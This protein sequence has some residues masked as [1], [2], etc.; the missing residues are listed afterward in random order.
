MVAEGLDDPEERLR[1]HAGCP[2]IH[3]KRKMTMRSSLLLLPV[4]IALLWFGP[5]PIRAQ[6][7]AAVSTEFIYN[8][9]DSCGQWID[10]DP[11]GYCWHPKDT[12]TDWHPYTIGRWVRTDAGWTWESDERFGWIVYHYG[13]WIR[14]SK[15]GWCWVPDTKWAPAWVSFREGGERVG[16]APLPPEARLSES[17]GIGEWAD[18]YYNIGPSA[19]RFLPIQR[20]G[21]RLTRE[22]FL[23]AADNITIFPGTVN[24]TSIQVGKNGVFVDGP[25]FNALSA[26]AEHPVVRMR[27][28][29]RDEFRS[30]NPY[31]QWSVAD[32]WVIVAPQAL[33][34]AEME[35]PR[36]FKKLLN[37]HI[38]HG[39]ESTTDPVRA[40]ELQAKLKA[41]E[42]LPPSLPAVPRFE[43]RLQESLGKTPLERF[44]EQSYIDRQCA[45]FRRERRSESDN[46]T[47]FGARKR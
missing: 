29:R 36:L 22:S 31:G 44:R 9:L 21:E 43:R 4:A 33:A 45:L 16:W 24:V 38:D 42:H 26:C 30:G 20:F 1:E 47:I 25:N 17:A 6:M 15:V 41:G 12:G 32:R 7:E 5:S 19:Y 34:P 13:R 23:G 11:Y 2:L 10:V 27:L 39:W 37:A 46:L 28:E 40:R 8:L 14:L 3:P 35:P 18:A